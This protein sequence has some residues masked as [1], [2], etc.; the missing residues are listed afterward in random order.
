MMLRLA[1]AALRPFAAAIMMMKPSPRSTQPIAIFVRLV[2]SWLRARAQHQR[3]VR[4]GVNRKIMNGLNAWYQVE[5]MR[6]GRCH[7]GI[8]QA[9]SGIADMPMLGSLG[10][11]VFLSAHSCRVL[12]CCSY[13]AQNDATMAQAMA[14]TPI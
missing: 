1:S 11:T 3:E 8:F 12:P 14:M 4:S 9:R 2:G 5:G 7:A 10:Q 13:T 6:S